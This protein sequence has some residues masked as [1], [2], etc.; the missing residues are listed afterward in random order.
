MPRGTG[1]PSAQRLMAEI[2]TFC[3]EQGIT[4]KMLA[5]ATG[6]RNTYKLL[7]GSIGS[8]SHDNEHLL[9]YWLNEAKAQH[10][11]GEAPDP[12]PRKEKEVQFALPLEQVPAVLDVPIDR[13]ADIELDLMQALAFVV[14][15]FRRTKQAS[16]LQVR[17]AVSWLRERAG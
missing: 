9:R 3:E 15:E 7:S 1:R 11:R 17:R 6:Y 13:N 2:R 16:G 14:E 12:P 8:L 5:E 4:P 10:A